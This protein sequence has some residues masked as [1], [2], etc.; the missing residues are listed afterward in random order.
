MSGPRRAGNVVDGR[1]SGDGIE[2]ATGQLEQVRQRQDAGQPTAVVQRDHVA[3]AASICDSEVGVADHA[4]LRRPR[5]PGG[6]V[7]RRQ[8][9]RGPIP[10]LGRRTVD[11]AGA[12]APTTPRRGRPAPS[13][14]A[15]RS[16]PGCASA[17]RPRRCAPLPRDSS[18]GR[19]ARRS[20]RASSTPRSRPVFATGSA[21]RGR[22]GRRS[23]CRGQPAR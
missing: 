15:L 2:Q 14:A 19:T 11:A 23:R 21:A 12:S 22:P 10:L 13:A 17:R 9:L 16:R 3:R 1:A 7:D 20:P 4:A 18:R 8:L 5:R 6:E